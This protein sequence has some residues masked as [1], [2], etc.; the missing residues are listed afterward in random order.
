MYMC[1]GAG[2]DSHVDRLSHNT[3]TLGNLLGGCSCSPGSEH[4]Q[5]K[6]CIYLVRM[7]Q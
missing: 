5:C 1:A 2:V 4:K 3:A 7:A 6:V